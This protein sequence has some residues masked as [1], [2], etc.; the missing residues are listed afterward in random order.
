MNIV[1]RFKRILFF[2]VTPGHI[3]PRELSVTQPFSS[4]CLGS[5]ISCKLLVIAHTISL[6]LLEVHRGR[7]SSRKTLRFNC[8]LKM[9]FFLRILKLK[10]MQFLYKNVYR[11]LLTFSNF[12]KNLRAGWLYWDF[13][14]DRVISQRHVLSFLK[15]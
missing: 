15:F 7:Y 1:T 5:L 9:W 12:L 10:N 8:T 14:F 6:F 2:R 13:K 3:P 11:Q 4:V